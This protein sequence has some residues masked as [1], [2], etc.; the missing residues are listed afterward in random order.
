VLL[1]MSR[2]SLAVSHIQY[3]KAMI[4]ETTYDTQFGVVGVRNMIRFADDK[5]VVSNTQKGLH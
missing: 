4:K 1:T 3:G 5:A 2:H